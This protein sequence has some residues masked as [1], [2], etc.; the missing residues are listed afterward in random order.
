MSAISTN[1]SP[2]AALRQAIRA[3][4]LSDVNFLAA[5]GG[6]KFYD[7]VPR[8]I[9]PPYVV[10]GDVIDR[11]WSTATDQGSEQI[12]R[13]DV[14]STQRG[15]LESLTIAGLLATLLQTPSLQIAGWTLVNFRYQTSETK[16]D[17]NGRFARTSLRYRAV[18]EKSN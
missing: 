15:L 14:W 4:V 18:L 6:A 5:L 17:A 1:A 11:D 8:G 9:E 13:L 10:F 3:K 2:V 7:E 16:R 12:I